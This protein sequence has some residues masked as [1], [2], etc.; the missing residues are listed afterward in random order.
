MRSMQRF[1]GTYRNQTARVGRGIS[2]EVVFK[3]FSLSLARNDLNL[4]DAAELN[5]SLLILTSKNELI[6]RVRS[7]ADTNFVGKRSAR[8]L[9]SCSCGLNVPCARAVFYLEFISIILILFSVS[10]HPI[11]ASRVAIHSLAYVI[12]KTADQKRNWFNFS[13]IFL[14]VSC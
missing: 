11:G 2:G 9:Q 3:F 8:Q 1:W 13:S 10:N 7:P 5:F 4:K 12:V 14:L 6:L